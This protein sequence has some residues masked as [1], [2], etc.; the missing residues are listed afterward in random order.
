MLVT[1]E[2]SSLELSAACCPGEAHGPLESGSQ[3]EGIGVSAP[4]TRDT[5]KYKQQA[6]HP[7]LTT[8]L[9]L[10]TVLNI[11]QMETAPK[12]DLLGEAAALVKGSTERERCG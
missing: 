2:R 6:G 1:G 3:A 4:L 11:G 7:A 10:V 8:R 12:I 5:K 9:C